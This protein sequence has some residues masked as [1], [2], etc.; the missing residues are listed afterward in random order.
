MDR[1]SE[2]AL[3]RRLRAGECA[4]FDAVFDQFHPRLF[5]F[6]A[7]LSRSRD[8]AE[9]LL[10]ETWL[11]F[12]AHASRLRPD[13]RLG[14]WLFTVAHHLFVSYCRSRLLD[15]TAASDLISLWPLASPSPSPFETAAVGEL[16]RRIEVALSTMPARHREV[17]LLV[18]VEGL[19]PG[20]AAVVCGIS[21]DALRQR[22]FRAR[23]MLAA[24]LETGVTPGK[25]STE[26]SSR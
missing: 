5:R 6:L 24:R 15:E 19:T 16:E 11:R 13:T 17:L 18:A 9:D 1:D 21:P 4:A 20:E 14:A 23:A 10:E 8:V 7:R 12:V 22:L 26:E 2:L 25:A 3:I